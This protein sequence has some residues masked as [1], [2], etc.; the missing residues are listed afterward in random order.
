MS[1]QLPELPYAMDALQPHISKETLEYHYGKHHL[2]YVNNLNQL[3]IDSPLAGSTLEQIIM[4]SEG[5][6]FNNAAQV[7]NH[8]FYWYC[9]SP[10][11]GGEP[12]G[13]LAQAIDE[14][15]GSFLA[16]KELFSKTALTTFGSGWA[17]LVL[18]EH[19]ELAVTSTSNADTPMRNRH[20][21]LLTCDVWEHAYYID[22]RN[23]RASY[24]DHFWNLVNWKF[25]SEQFGE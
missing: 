18:D 1:F 21:A 3:L 20:K 25:V 7:W 12:T 6:L 9:L 17:W 10:Q 22:Y 5:G 24:I 13:K 2:T 4:K 19:G 8:T 16:F 11:G 15:F 14:K 23:A